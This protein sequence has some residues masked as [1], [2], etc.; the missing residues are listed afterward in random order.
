MPERTEPIG[1]Q[2]W[3]SW[4]GVDVLTL[5]DVPPGRGGIVI[6]GIN[7][8]PVS[9]RAGHYY[10]G[11]L[12]KRVW[13][14]LASIGALPPGASWEDERWRAAGNGLTDVVKRPT[15]SAKEV[16]EVE[17][18][19]GGASLME[20]LGDWQPG[21]ILFPFMAAAE[22]VLGVA[23]PPGP[24][25]TVDGIATFRLAGPYA[26]TADVER[27][28]Q[29]LRAQLGAPELAHHGALASAPWSRPSTASIEEDVHSQPVTATD[30]AAGRIRFPRAAKRFWYATRNE[31]QTTFRAMEPDRYGAFEEWPEGFFDQSSRESEQILRAV[32]RKRR[33]R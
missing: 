4:R 19:E 26:P 28:G 30:R 24:G 1:L 15:G 16:L 21:L 9:V 27:N 6:V 11:A 8:S 33:G 14:R 23:P 2:E 31:G 12:G 29:E 5:S 32:A 7:P 25:P 18:A 20:K 3:I 13:S 17:L 22:V 10:Q